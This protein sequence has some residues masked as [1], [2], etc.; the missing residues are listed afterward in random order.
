MSISIIGC[1]HV[2]T[3]TGA[4]LA[5]VGNNIFFIDT[6]ENKVNALNSVRSPLAEPWLEKLIEKNRER[7]HA[8]TDI[9]DIRYSDIIFICVGTPQKEDGS[10]DLSQIRAASMGVGKVLQGTMNYRLVVVKSTVVPGTTDS[11]I[12]PIIERKANKDR[13]ELGV[14]MN[15]EFLRE[16]V[17]VRDFLSPDRIVCGVSD[18]RAELI[19]RKLYEPFACPTLFTDIKTA[20]MIKYANNAFL[21]TKI[22]FANEIGNICK[23]IGVDTDDVFKAVG[24]DRRINPAFFTAGVGFGGSCFPKDVRALIAFAEKM[25]ENPKLLRATMSVNGLQPEKMIEILRKYVPDLRGAIIGVLGLSVKPGT[26]DIR[27]SRAIPIVGR[28]HMEGATVIAHDPLAMKAFKKL[29]MPGQPIE[30]GTA[31]EVLEASVILILTDWPVYEGLDYSGKIVI[32][33]RRVMRAKH[34]AAIYEAVC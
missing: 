2:G 23:R 30:F 11:F 4:G 13:D 7:I 21:A 28:L 25:G 5:A 17:A 33:G 24:C 32:D 34:Q 27:E 9:N 1:G 20:E 12:R 22:S 29:C 8:S 18:S 26:D 6:D 15:P 19:L 10:I 14:A 3:V 16:G 31:E